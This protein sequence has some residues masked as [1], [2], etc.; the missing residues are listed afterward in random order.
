LKST[1]F[2]IK[3]INS[4]LPRVLAVDRLAAHRE[5]QRI[6][7]TKNKSSSKRNVEQRLDRLQKRLEASEQKRNL[8]LKNLPDLRFNEELPIFAKK[9]EII[10]AITRHPVIVVSG[11]TGSGK[12][13]QLP[14]FCLAAGR[15]I[16][17]IAPAA[18][19]KNWDRK[20]VKRLDIKFDLRSA[21]PGMP[22]SRS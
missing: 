16:D 10:D 20:P 2:Y 8:R 15:G 3:K 1:Q 22:I 9:D 7:R 17:G 18:S 4:Y 19:L 21:R 11:E 6:V 5:I 13:T 14:K 12:T